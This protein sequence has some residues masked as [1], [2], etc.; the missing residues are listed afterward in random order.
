[1][2][3]FHL[4]HIDLDG[5][6]AQFIAKHFFE[7]IYFFNANYGKEIQIR[8]N[9]MLDCI[10][11]QNKEEK[12]LFLI[13]DLNLTLAESTLL[14]EQIAE[15]KIQSYNIDLMLLDHHISGSESSRQF[16]WYSLDISRSACKITFDTLLEQYPLLN[17]S[18]QQWLLDFSNMVNAVDIWKT[19]EERFEFGKVA[20]GMIANLKDPNRLMFDEENRQIKFFML[21]KIKDYLY[22]QKGEVKFDN[23][24]FMLKKLAFNGNPQEETMDNIFASFLVS[25]LQHKKEDLRIDYKGHK[26]ILTY[27]LG[28]VSV[29]GN[30][31]LMQNPDFHFILDVNMR[32]NVSLRANHQLDVSLLAEEYFG[33]GGHKNASGGKIDNFRESFFYDQIK[34]QI[35][36]ILQS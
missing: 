7:E 36:T 15:L 22:L 33:G 3:V 23:D 18:K 16:H 6:G 35:E 21:E 10:K 25:L 5:Y 34:Y 24:L 12:I 20:M 31:F 8:I 26:G 17:P 19:Q 29:V 14:Q 13:T 1:M 28:N 27:M 32:G 9:A 2:K 4:S 30:Q 11:T